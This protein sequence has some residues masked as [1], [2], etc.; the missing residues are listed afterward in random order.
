[1]AIDL[2]LTGFAPFAGAARNPSGELARVFDGERVGGR[3]VRGA[4]L[5]VERKRAPEQLH[6]LLRELRPRAVVALG[7]GDGGVVRVERVAVNL[8]DFAIPDESGEQ[9]R[10]SEIRAGGADALRATL[11][12]DALVAAVRAAGVPALASLSAGSFLC[13]LVFYELLAV[14]REAAS[15]SAN[16]PHRAVFVHLPLLPES[17]AAAENERPSMALETSRIAVE[18]VLQAII[19]ALD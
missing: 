5:V 1:M 9:P 15:G 11:P 19:A 7:Q 2:L 13:N 14:A 4:E 3:V 18:A 10:A 16:E 6:E 8:L 17:V 12:V